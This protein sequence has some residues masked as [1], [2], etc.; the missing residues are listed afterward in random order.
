MTTKDLA[1]ALRLLCKMNR[2]FVAAGVQSYEMGSEVDRKWRLA[3]AA[4]AS[5]D[6]AQSAGEA[7]A[8][9]PK[10]MR[11]RDEWMSDEIREAVKQD[12]NLLD[13]LGSYKTKVVELHGVFE[14]EVRPLLA[15]AAPPSPAVERDERAAFEAWAGDAYVFTNPETI[16]RDK[17]RTSYFYG[18]IKYA[19][20]AWQARA[21]L[22]GEKP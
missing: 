5:H 15:E 6:A 18:P 16:T 17:T 2:E 3:T 1:E 21:A 20:S 12:C 9:P 19:W 14:R 13:D 8:V 7:Q 11:I 22:E 4:L 10:I